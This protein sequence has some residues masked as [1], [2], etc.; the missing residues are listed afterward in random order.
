MEDLRNRLR[1]MLSGAYDQGV[2]EE[3]LRV[4]GSE[5]GL[6]FVDRGRGSSLV[7]SDLYSFTRV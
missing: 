5:S 7:S 1:N 6:Q 4:G 2:L 3:V